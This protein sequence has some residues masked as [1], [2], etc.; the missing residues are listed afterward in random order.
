MY[1]VAVTGYLLLIAGNC[2]LEANCMSLSLSGEG[3]TILY[4][5]AEFQF[6][7]SDLLSDLSGCC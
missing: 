6:S 4:L 5:K 3:V 1:D 2:G 7:S